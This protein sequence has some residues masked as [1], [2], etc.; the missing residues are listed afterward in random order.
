MI[1]YLIKDITTVDRGMIAHGVNCQR[2][3]GAGVAKAIKDKWPII[4]QVYMA[5]PA[6]P[7]MLG[8]HHWVAVGEDL[9]VA[10][11]Y[12]QVFCGSNGRYAD[13][14]AIYKSLFGVCTIAQEKK[15]PLYIPKIGAGLGGLSWTDEVEPVIKQ[16]DEQFPDVDIYVCDI[17]GE[18]T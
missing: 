16:L 15:L 3:M 1:S 11:C 14:Q 17:E 2:A 8:V 5:Y 6:D 18:T 7:N 10:N 4:Y 13:P 9:Y 12:T